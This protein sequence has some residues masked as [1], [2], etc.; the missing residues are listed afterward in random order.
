MENVSG[1]LFFCNEDSD[2]LVK[3]DVNSNKYSFVDPLYRSFAIAL[4]SKSGPKLSGDKTQVD[5]S[6]MFEKLRNQLAKDSRT[7]IVFRVLQD[8]GQ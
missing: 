7:E 4:F 6:R 8:K 3:H 1:P 5:I 2:S